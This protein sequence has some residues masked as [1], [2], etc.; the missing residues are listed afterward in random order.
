MSNE[1]WTH[2]LGQMTDE[3]VET[4]RSYC[5]GYNYQG[6]GFTFL[7][8][9]IWRQDY[10]LNWT[11]MD[12]YMMFENLFQM[13]DGRTAGVFA[14]PLTRTGKYEKDS[15]RKVILEGRKMFTEKGIPFSV[16]LIPGAL[17]D[18]LQEAVPELEFEH[19]RDDDEY[20]YDRDKLTTLSGRALHKKKNHMNYFKKTYAYEAK[21]LTKDMQAE[22]IALT[23]LIRDGK[24]RSDDE[25]RSLSEERHAIQEVTKFLDRDDVY[26]V[27]IFIDG[28]LQAYAIGERMSEDTAAEHFEKAN[29][30][31]RGLYQVVCSEFCKQLPEE[32][33]FVNREEDMGLPNLRHAKEALKPHHM[34]EMYNAWFPEDR[35]ELL[36]M[37]LIGDQLD[38]RLEEENQAEAKSE[39]EPQV[40]AMSEDPLRTASD[41]V[42]AAA[43]ETVPQEAASAGSAANAAD[44][45]NEVPQEWT[46]RDHDC[47]ML[48]PD[49]AGSC[50]HCAAEVSCRLVHTA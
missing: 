35:E 24:E 4:L 6:A 25:M 37:G 36:S 46:F 11:E 3:D 13:E 7:A 33:R 48:V 47:G 9:Y 27:G 44:T 18:I 29:L 14:M 20:V 32:I 31:F 2:S 22:I 43:K 12:S 17:K 45:G 15:L 16:R 19:D 39:K 5:N 1:K 8:N 42:T 38:E 30:Q 40:A 26:T 10:D 21:P 34:S 41:S 28:R 23:E 49:T 50:S